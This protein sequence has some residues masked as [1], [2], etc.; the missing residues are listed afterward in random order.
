[1]VGM[2]ECQGHI[3]GLAN[4]GRTIPHGSLLLLLLSFNETVLII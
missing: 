4:Q 3:R 1:M 2:V